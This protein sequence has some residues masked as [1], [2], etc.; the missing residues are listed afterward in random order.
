MR[1]VIAVCLALSIAGCTSKSKE[2]DQAVDPALAKEIST[3]EV[4]YTQNC[5]TCHQADGSGAPPLNPPLIKTSFVTGD[6]NALIDI[7]VNGMK[8]QKVDGK[9]YKNVMPS[10]DYLKEE[11]IAN[12]LTFIRNSFGN[13]ADMI[14]IEDVKTFRNSAQNK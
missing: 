2:S 13:K 10:F 1:F 11:E 5:A 12:V 4:V 7:V 3:G 14:T 8:N 9:T 6:K